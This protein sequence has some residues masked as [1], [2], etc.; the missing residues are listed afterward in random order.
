[1]RLT[2][3]SLDRLSSSAQTLKAREQLVSN[4]PFAKILL[5]RSFKTA[6]DPGFAEGRSIIECEKTQG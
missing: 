5:S 2:I 6:K 4:I 3:N 1:M